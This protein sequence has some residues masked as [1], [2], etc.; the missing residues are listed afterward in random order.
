MAS[1][2]RLTGCLRACPKACLPHGCFESF[3]TRAYC[4]PPGNSVSPNPSWDSTSSGKPSLPPAFAWC[5]CRKG[6]PDAK[7]F[8]RHPGP[9]REGTQNHSLGCD[10]KVTPHP[11]PPCD[12]SVSCFPVKKWDPELL[13]AWLGPQCGLSGLGQSTVSVRIVDEQIKQEMGEQVPQPLA[14]PLGGH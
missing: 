9:W 1:L 3:Y 2:L 12:C 14:G 4:C 8:H 6:L 5:C 11:Q 13:E 7:A 10:L